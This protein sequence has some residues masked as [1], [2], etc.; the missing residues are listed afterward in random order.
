[1]RRKVVEVVVEEV[2]AVF[3]DYKKDVLMIKIVYYVANIG[4]IDK[5]M[6]RLYY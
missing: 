6:Y 4:Y 3:N 5:N 1:M 2:I